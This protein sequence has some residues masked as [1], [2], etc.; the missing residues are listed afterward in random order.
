MIVSVPAVV[1][2]LAG[3]AVICLQSLFS[4]TLGERVGVMGSVF[5]IHAGGLLLAALF[6]LGVRGGALSAW[7]SVPWYALCAG[8]LGVGIVAAVSY[9]VPRLGLAAERLRGAQRRLQA[10]SPLGVLQRGYAVVT[11]KADGA[12]I[13]SISQVA[14][15][16]GLSVRVRD[17]EFE[18]R[19]AGEK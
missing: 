13:Q 2:A 15:G 19:V 7:R 10:L 18:A 6:I 8:F 5:I 11:R 3:G 14:P 17:G 1:A 16:D 12:L 4:G 9:T